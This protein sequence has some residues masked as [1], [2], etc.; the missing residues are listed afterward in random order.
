MHTPQ[1]TLW[2]DSR[3]YHGSL[4]L[5]ALERSTEMSKSAPTVPPPKETQSLDLHQQKRS[6]QANA[7][8]MGD[9]HTVY[10]HTHSIIT[11][12]NARPGWA[13]EKCGF[14]GLLRR[15]GVIRVFAVCFGRFCG[16]FS[17]VFRRRTTGVEHGQRSSG[18]NA[19]CAYCSYY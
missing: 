6:N 13:T 12:L 9:M 16:F 14:K 1:L 15:G 10:C 19:S 3:Y 2:Y 4:F 5:H 7:I 18:L 17:V 8:S 11:S